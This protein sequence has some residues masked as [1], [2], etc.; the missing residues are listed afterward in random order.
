MSRKI[1]IFVKVLFIS[2]FQFCFNYSNAQLS[3]SLLTCSQPGGDG[4]PFTIK[5][6]GNTAEVT[7]KGNL[8]KPKFTE[9]W[10]GMKG[11]KWTEYVGDGI[12]ASTTASDG[13]VSIRSLQFPKS[14]PISTCYV[15]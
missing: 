10:V 15:R 8:Y 11:D 1:T 3:S 5:F 4:I 2:L 13:Y 6:L 14:P 12:I 7:F 9:N